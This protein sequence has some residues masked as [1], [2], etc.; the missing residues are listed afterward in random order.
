MLILCD[1]G[2]SNGY[3][4]RL[5]KLQLQTQLA[6]QFDLEVMVCH[7]PTGASKYNPIERRLFSPISV[8]WAGTP[9]RSFEMMLGYIRDTSNKTGLSIT[10]FLLDR[11]YKIGKKVSD[12]EMKALN[13]TRR[14]ICPKWNYIIKPRQKVL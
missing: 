2:V 5:W 11:K 8:N 14:R 10:A 7:Y 3:R 13:L 9:L 12:A 1:G 4:P 6:D